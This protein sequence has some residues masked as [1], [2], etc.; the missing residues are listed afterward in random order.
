MK[1]GIWFVILAVLMIAA[2]VACTPADNTGDGEGDEEPPMPTTIDLI[3]NSESD[4]TIVYDDSDATIKAEV[5]AFVKRLDQK[6]FLT[7]K[8]VGLSEA[9]DDYGHEI[10]IGDARASGKTVLEQLKGGDFAM[11]VVEDDWV[12]CASNSRLYAYLFDV[13]FSE[14]FAGYR[15]GNLTLSSE[16]N[17]FYLDSDLSGT[18]YVEYLKKRK[19]EGSA[20]IEKIFEYC[21]F[22]AEDGTTLPYRLYV[23]YDYDPTK[24]YPVL[25]VLHGA[26]QRGT[27][28]LGGVKHM[29]PQMYA[30]ENT[31]M[32]EAIV[33]CP[34][35]PAAP[36]QWVD[37][38]WAKGNYSVDDVPMSNEL[39]A[40][41]ELLDEIE[42]EYSTD[43]DRYYVTG[44]SMGGFGT[45]DLLMRYPDKF[46]A[47]VPICGGADPSYADVLRDVPIF[48]VHSTDDPTVPAKGTQEMVKALRD[49]GSTVLKYQELEGMGHGVWNWTAEN[50][51]VWKWLFEQ[52]LSDR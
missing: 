24:D 13:L 14:A 5:E 31:P 26:G 39:E 47:G 2:L 46:A 8:A 28:N 11:C 9:E 27:D 49:A 3:V 29:L 16:N 36:N 7:V 17:F 41:L 34:Q 19:T 12:L 35:C 43:P 30:H 6:F 10:V 37:T 1:K 33:F 15:D 21:T 52:K 42:E 51:E 4:Y 18:N 32:A 20:L 25:I 45:W 48:T 38:P 50:I 44:L 23:P 40:V 22:T